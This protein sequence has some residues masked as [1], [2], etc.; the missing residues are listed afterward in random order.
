MRADIRSNSPL[1]LSEGEG[2]D[3]VHESGGAYLEGAGSDLDEAILAVEGDGA[4][5]VGMNAEEKAFGLL[6]AGVGDSELHH[7]AS[8]AAA[9]EFGEE[10]DAPELEVTRLCEASGEVGCGEHGVADGCGSG[11]NF[12]EP[13]SS[14]GFFEVGEVGVRDVVLRAVGKEGVAGDEA[15]EGLEQGCC[16]DESERGCVRG[17]AFAEVYKL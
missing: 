4:E 16:G 1:P 17:S 8:G 9:V 7:P 2:E 14:L 6:A 15:S 11:G 10:I 12:S 5:V 3:G 13:C